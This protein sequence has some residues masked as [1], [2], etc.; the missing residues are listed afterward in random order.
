[1]SIATKKSFSYLESANFGV[2][3]RSALGPI[4]FPGYTSPVGVILNNFN[5]SVLL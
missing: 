2:A 3:Q 1:M 4:L 5:F